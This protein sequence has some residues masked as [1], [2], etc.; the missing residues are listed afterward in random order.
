VFRTLCGDG[1]LSELVKLDGVRGDVSDEAMDEFGFPLIH[2]R[3]AG[4][5]R[6]LFA[7]GVIEALAR[8]C[9]PQPMGIVADNNE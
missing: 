2:P 9:E 1:T 7:C 5:M 6:A 4:S 8:E 3:G